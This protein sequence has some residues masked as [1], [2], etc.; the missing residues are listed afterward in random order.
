MTDER[1]QLPFPPEPSRSGAFFSMIEQKFPLQGD[2]PPLGMGLDLSWLEENTNTI[3]KAMKHFVGDSSSGMQVGKWHSATGNSVAHPLVVP[4]A[5]I[6]KVM[7]HLGRILYVRASLA[8]WLPNMGSLPASITG[9]YS[10]YRCELAE[11]WFL[12]YPQSCPDGT[13]KEMERTS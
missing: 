11:N 13:G 12:D 9:V 4:Q 8:Q 5:S 6:F 7:L 3:L 10:R 1:K 2:L